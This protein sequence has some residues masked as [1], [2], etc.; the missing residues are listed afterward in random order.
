MF[1][2]AGAHDTTGQRVRA[3]AA[4]V[5]LLPHSVVAVSPMGQERRDV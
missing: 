1:L 3:L 4:P 5:M 2:T